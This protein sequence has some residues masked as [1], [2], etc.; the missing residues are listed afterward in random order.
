MNKVH[1]DICCHATA[2]KYKEDPI[3]KSSRGKGKLVNNLAENI[4]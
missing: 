4:G 1:P 3:T 2:I